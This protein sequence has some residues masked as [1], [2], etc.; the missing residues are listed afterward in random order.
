MGTFPCHLIFKEEAGRFFFGFGVF[1]PLHSSNVAME[2]VEADSI[3]KNGPDRDFLVGLGRAR[4][5][6]NTNALPSQ[7]SAKVFDLFFVRSLISVFGS[8]APVGGFCSS[9]VW[10]P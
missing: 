2:M 4:C 5:D 10:I 8:F 3:K 9:A 7:V 1:A 6:A